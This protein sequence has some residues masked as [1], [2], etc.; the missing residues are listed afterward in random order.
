[1]PPKRRTSTPTAR[2][3]QQRS[4]STLSFGKGAPNRVTKPAVAQQGKRSKK[5]PSL[6]DITTGDAEPEIDEPTTAEVAIEE[7][8]AAAVKTEN[9]A[10]EDPLADHISAKTE[11]VL[12]GRASESQIGAVGGR[13]GSGWV[14]NEEA[15]ARKITESQIKAYWRGK[16]RERKAPRVHQEGLTVAEKMLREFDMSGHF[17][18]SR[19]RRASMRIHCSE[20][21]M[22]THCIAMYRYC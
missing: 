7:Q 2:A 18:V 17:G 21:I 20:D 3:Q 12:G 1:M 14:G 13:G 9:T 5:D 19:R 22:L 4:Q 6:L 16:E 10:A 11:D 8:A 15:E